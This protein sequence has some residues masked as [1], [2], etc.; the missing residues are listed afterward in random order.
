MALTDG[1]SKA[2]ISELV[3]KEKSATAIGAYLTATG[4]IM[5]VASTLAGFLWKY[6][7]PSAPFYLGAA[8]AT[9]AAILFMTLLRNKK[10]AL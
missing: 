1:I 6:V 5:F 9:I 2:Y 3:P 10:Y 8:T 7:S 4:L